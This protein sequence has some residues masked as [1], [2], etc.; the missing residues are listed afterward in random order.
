MDES[1]KDKK[2]V[3]AEALGKLI[4]EEYY[5]PK[6]EGGVKPPAVSADGMSFVYPTGLGPE[7][8]DAF[9]AYINKMREDSQGMK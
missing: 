6:T 8:K 7:E 5:S 9:D 3:Q 4:Y 2:K 1:L